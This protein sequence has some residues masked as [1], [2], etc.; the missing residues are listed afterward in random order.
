MSLTGKTPS[1]SYKDLAYV[2]NSNNG[3]TTSLKQI[4]TG[5]GGSTCLKVSDRSLEVKSATNNTTALDIKNASGASKLLVDTTNDYV[6]ANGI[7]VNTNYAYFGISFAT[8]LNFVANTHYLLPFS[9]ENMGSTLSANVPDIGTGT[10]PD[11]TFTTAEANSQ[12]AGQL[13]P[14]LWY[15]PDN[16][17]IDGVHSLE[18]A[19]TATG[20]TTRMHLMSYTFTSGSTSAL[21]DGTLLAHNSDVTNAGSEQVYLSNWTVDSGNVTAG[22]VICATFRSDSVN[23]DYGARIFIK[24]HITG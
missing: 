18:G 22:K 13:A 6:K 23:S 3:V 12:R 10:D 15:L 4:K 1:G 7:H 16:I 9:G 11:T 24:Y 5:D 8:M 17:S 20:D 2:D 21:T 19:D 14:L